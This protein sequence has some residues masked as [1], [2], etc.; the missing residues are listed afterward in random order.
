MFVHHPPFN[1]IDSTYSI[2][3]KGKIR[4]L[5]R[6]VHSRNVDNCQ[7]LSN[8][9]TNDFVV[10]SKRH[11]P[12]HRCENRT[13]NTYVVKT[14]DTKDKKLLTFM[15]QTRN[16][17]RAIFDRLVHSL[18]LFFLSFVSFMNLKPSTTDK[19]SQSKRKRV[20]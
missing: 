5:A 15:R 13:A 14:N 3:V 6:R 11:I 4:I 2:S 8:V 16:C 7:Q 10:D 20:T 9:R 19:F 18:R 17:M 1:E 12:A